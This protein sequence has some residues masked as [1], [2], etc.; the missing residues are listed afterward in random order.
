MIIRLNFTDRYNQLG[1]CNNFSRL[2][3][4]LLKSVFLSIFLKMVSDF[5]KI[6]VQLVFA[7]AASKHNVIP[8][9]FLLDI[10]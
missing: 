5:E 3:Y 9:G 2:V 7:A 1:I 10:H 8:Q 4:Q 6:E